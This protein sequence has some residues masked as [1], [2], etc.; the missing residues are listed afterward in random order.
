MTTIKEFKT[1]QNLDKFRDNYNN[2]RKYRMQEVF[3]NN[4]FGLQLTTKMQI[5]I[6]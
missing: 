2:Q 3:I 1:Q 5:D 6:K 4:S